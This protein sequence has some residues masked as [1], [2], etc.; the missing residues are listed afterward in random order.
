[1][2]ISNILTIY[3]QQLAYLKQLLEVVTEKRK[4]LIS[5]KYDEF[6][7]AT[8]KEEK[9]LMHV[10]ATEKQRGLVV[11]NVFCKYFPNLPDRTKAKLSLL[12]RGLVPPRDLARLSGL[13][14]AIRN[15]VNL[16]GE[17]NKHNLFLL[18]HLK[19]F[20]GDIMQALIGNKRAAI[21]D[22]KI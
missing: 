4:A 2:D 6:E 11:E 19:V 21:V 13:E 15:T 12:L 22:R 16:L 17:E 18:H 5:S 10:Q 3:D 20:Y 9:I 1:M 14:M 7:I 8:R